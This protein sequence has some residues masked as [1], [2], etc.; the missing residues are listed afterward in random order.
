ML[1]S[2]G[3]VTVGG[4]P[5]SRGARMMLKPSSVSTREMPAPPRYLPIAKARLAW[6][7]PPN[8]D[9]Y[10]RA[11]ATFRWDV[12]CRELDGLPDGRGLNIAHEAVDRHVAKG[13][14]DRLAIRWLGKNGEQSD[15]DYRLLMEQT[16]RFANVLRGLG[17]APGSAFSRSCP[18]GP[19]STSH[20]SGR[21]RTGV[22]S[23]PCS[24]RSVPS[25]SL[26]V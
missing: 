17:V 6:R 4:P 21:S 10:E 20:A 3:P 5:E 2:D 8:L 19:S 25:R 15:F 9:D 13:R 22:C 16:S 23:L 1:A 24:R 12:A 11:R 14:G 18:G 7:V 26:H